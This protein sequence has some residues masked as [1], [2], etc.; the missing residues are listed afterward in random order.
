MLINNLI[1]NAIRHT[2]AKG[3]ISIRL[4]D[5][6][7]EITNSGTESLDAEL[8]FKRFSKLSQGSKGSGLGL[9]IISEICKFQNWSISYQ[10][11]KQHH[12]F[13]VRF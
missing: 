5:S 10:F 9:A 3:F 13:S 4:T 7:F 2:L 11:E 1:L 6:V 8:L 12:I